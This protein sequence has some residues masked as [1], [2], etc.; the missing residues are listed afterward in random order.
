MENIMFE[1]IIPGL[2]TNGA[3]DIIRKIFNSKVEGDID[4]LSKKILIAYNEAAKEFYKKYGYKYG[5]ETNSFLV[6]Q[7]NIDK[8]VNILF[9]ENY[10]EIEE[11]E[12]I[13]Y[14]YD[15]KALLE[16]DIEALKWFKNELKHKISQDWILE[17]TIMSP[18]IKTEMAGS[19]RNILPS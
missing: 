8:L 19:L 5:D 1:Q 15:E 13:K 2:L 18:A 12:F 6:R 16:V 14:G 11:L 17:Q 3:Y 4:V 9:N 7:K 10:Q